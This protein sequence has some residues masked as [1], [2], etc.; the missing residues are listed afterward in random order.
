[1]TEHLDIQKLS[2]LPVIPITIGDMQFNRT[3]L[4][5]FLEPVIREKAA[6][7]R[8]ACPLGMPSPAFIN[9]LAGQDVDRALARIME[10]NPLPGITGRLCYHPCQ[11]GCLRRAL[12][13]PI[14]IQA[15]ERHIA[16]TGGEP[17]VPMN[18]APE[19][20]VAVLGAGPAGLTAAYFLGRAGIHTTVIDTLDRAG[21]FL[22]GVEEKKLPRA[23]LAKEVERLCRLAALELHL[24]V[25]AHTVD[26]PAPGRDWD[27]VIY[28]ESAHT[29]G[30]AAGAGLAHL[31]ERMSGS[32]PLVDTENLFPPEGYKVSQV[33]VTVAAGRLLAVRAV[34][35]MGLEIEGLTGE[36]TEGDDLGSAPVEEKDIRFDLFAAQTKPIID[37]SA[38]TI[39][40]AQARQE[41]ERCLSC[42]RCNLCGRCLIFCPD[43]SLAVDKESRR[44][45][46]DLEH[47]KGCGI[48]AHECPRRV[49]VMERKS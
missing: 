47:C 32:F 28:D 31:A 45:V 29:G 10:V 22:A 23:V 12:D 8:Q 4:W 27:L 42:G 34:E 26:D 37:S 18:V 6:P 30:T 39:S 20:H 43:V 3:G 46:V 41:A 24:N 38:K 16:E 5:R 14:H 49:I 13:R 15:L 40:D 21:G 35:A 9:D 1:M 36:V 48:C 25:D 7:C 33:A 19:R 44:P 17:D 2:D 11:A